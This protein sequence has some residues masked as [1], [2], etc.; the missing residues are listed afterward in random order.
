MKS[1]TNKK[2]IKKYVKM[3]HQLSLTFFFI[4]TFFIFSFG[5]IIFLLK[6]NGFNI[7]SK[8]FHVV[9]S[10]M[11]YTICSI[12]SS[13]ILCFAVWN[14]FKPLKE[15]S[16]ASKKIAKG[17]Y[18]IRLKYDGKITELADTIENVNHM[19]EELGSVEMIRNDFIANVSHEFKTP[20]SS[21]NGY[22]TLLQ[23]N[24]ISNTERNEYISKAFFSIEKLNDLTDNILKL[25]K[26][27]HQTVLDKPVEYRLDEQIRE[28]IVILEPKWSKKNIDFEIDMSE[29]KY[30]GQKSLL[31]QVWTNILSNAIKFSYDGGTIKVN[32]EY[33][34]SQYKIYIGDDGI[35]MTDEQQR[36]IFEKF[37]QADTLAI[38]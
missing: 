38:A 22:L 35:G 28:A 13:S 31:F 11:V 20:L 30:I 10:F 14:L 21:L 15:I 9:F 37:Y 3:V 12:F 34:D 2:V 24:S 7:L 1:K 26:L 17:D 32:L 18:S 4:S 6:S 5:L 8:S 36:H 19:A 16:R 27:E 29:V 25:S 33:S 23:D